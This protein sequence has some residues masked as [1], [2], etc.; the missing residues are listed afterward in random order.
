MYNGDAGEP[1]CDPTVRQQGA[2]MSRTIDIDKLHADTNVIAAVA[3]AD[4][5]FGFLKRSMRVPGRFIALVT[6]RSGEKTVRP[7]DAELTDDDVADVLFV[8]NQPIE[9]HIEPGEVASSDS[10]LC[11]SAVRLEVRLLEDRQELEAFRDRVVGSASSVDT[12]RLAGY[13]MASIQQAVSRFAAD[14]LAGALLDPATAASCS[15]AVS[16]ALAPLCFEGGMTLHTE[17]RVR[18]ECAA[19]QR[20]KQAEQRAARQLGEH[21]AQQQLRDALDD[22][23]KQRFSELET[24]LDRLSA[25]A[26]ES[27]DANLTQLMRAFSEAQRGELY[28]AMFAS[29]SR[30]RLTQWIVVVAGTRLLYFDSQSP[31]TVAQ[32][33][34]VDGA[35]GPLR[36]PRLCSPCT[37]PGPL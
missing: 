18:F 6:R 1:F 34:E 26:G 17:P 9:L 30:E 24:M 35:A 23:R 5:L 33:V 2:T 25:M 22:A 21:A 8:R 11:Q 14:K 13:F 32:T 27:P 36:R 3:T 4:Q 10:Y 29:G 7:A 19:Y 31:D 37:G 20:V 15:Q 12:R 16:E 28:E